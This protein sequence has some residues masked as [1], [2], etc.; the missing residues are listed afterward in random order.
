L[1]FWLLLFKKDGL[2]FIIVGWTFNKA[3]NAHSDQIVDD[4]SA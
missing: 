1:M 3:I 2:V 4:M